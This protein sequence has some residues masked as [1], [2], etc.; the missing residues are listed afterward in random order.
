VDDK[1]VF[2][3]NVPVE[4]PAKGRH[5][6]T[7]T[8]TLPEIEIMYADDYKDARLLADIREIEL[9]ALLVYDGFVEGLPADETGQYGFRVEG[10]VHASDCA[11]WV[12]EPCDCT[13]G[14][15]VLRG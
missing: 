14:K 1:I 9:H 10:I 15:D 3:T 4:I 7:A 6:D 12:H 11:A 5:G 8:A 13:I 2:Q